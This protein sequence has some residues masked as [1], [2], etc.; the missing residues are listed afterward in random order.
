[1]SGN[2]VGGQAMALNDSGV[3][4]GGGADEEFDF[5]AHQFDVEGGK[6]GEQQQ[7]QAEAVAA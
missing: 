1:M 7:Q 2:V 6:G 4:W 5:D 3:S